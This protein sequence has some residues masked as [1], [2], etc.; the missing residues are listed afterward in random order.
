MQLTQTQ[1]KDSYG[2]DC[3]SQDFLVLLSRS[4]L[5]EGGHVEGLIA[6]KFRLMCIWAQVLTVKQPSQISSS[7]LTIRYLEVQ[8]KTYWENIGPAGLKG[9]TRSTIHQNAA[10]QSPKLLSPAKLLTPANSR[11]VLLFTSPSPTPQR[12]S[13]QYKAQSNTPN[14]ILREIFS[15]SHSLSFKPNGNC[16]DLFKTI[17]S[18]RPFLW[19]L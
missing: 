19:W 1:R 16:N 15:V 10:S 8:T 13:P 11:K 12:V 7:Q 3:H 9:S 6:L 2:L 14:C 5:I 4:R 17:L 18:S